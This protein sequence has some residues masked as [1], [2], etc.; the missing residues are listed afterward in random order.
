[1]LYTIILEFLNLERD[2]SI[3][4]ATKL[5]AKVFTGTTDLAVVQVWMTKIERVFDIIDCS[6][7]RKLCLI[8]FSLEEG[9]YNWWQSVRS[10]YLDPSIITWTDFSRIFY[11]AYY[12]RSY[13][14]AR[15]EKFLNLVQGRFENG[16]REEIRLVVTTAG[17]NIFG[18]LVESALR[19]EKSISDRPDDREQTTI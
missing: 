15:Q 1:M 11:Y 10:T 2:F 12:P 13:K 19:V 9:A 17:R 14:D 3:E 8:T 4:R 6:D 5:G 16:L 7:D 18:K